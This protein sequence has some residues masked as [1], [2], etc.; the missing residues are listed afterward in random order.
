MGIVRKDSGL[1]LHGSW[2]GL[3]AERLRT[4]RLE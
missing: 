1:Y 2:E 4:V 3:I